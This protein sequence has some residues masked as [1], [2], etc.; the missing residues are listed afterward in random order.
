LREKLAAALS[1]LL[2]PELRNGLRGQQA[3]AQTVIGLFDF[4]HNVLHAHDGIDDWWNLTPMLRTTHREKS[5]RDTAIVAK[6]KRLR[7]KWVD[8]HTA[9]GL[10]EVEPA[11]RKRPRRRLRGRGFDK[12]RTRH[13]DGTVTPR[14]SGK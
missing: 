9:I 7:R 11:K 3:P 8:P 13:L 2:L 10:L 12:S 14:K 5:R 1:M 6:V 4:D